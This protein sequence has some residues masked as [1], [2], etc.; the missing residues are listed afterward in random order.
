MSGRRD[1][2]FRCRHCGMGLWVEDLSGP[3]TIRCHRCRQEHDVDPL[4][5]TPD[6]ELTACFV[7]G[8]DRLYRQRD[9]NRKVG[10]AIVAVAAVFSVKTY[11]LSLLAAAIIDLWLYT[12][13]PEIALCY[14]CEAIHRG[15]GLPDSIEAYDLATQE[16]YEDKEWGK[17]HETDPA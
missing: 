8:C 11:G 1:V 10:L 13:L 16:R 2:N 9:F 15:F 3:T 5:Q 6:G 12:R 14:H 17:R 7:C 4:R